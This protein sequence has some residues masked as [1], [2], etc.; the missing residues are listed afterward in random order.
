MIL[1]IPADR[2]MATYRGTGYTMAMSET[3]VAAADPQSFKKFRQ[4]SCSSP[5]AIRLIHLFKAS[6]I[7]DTERTNRNDNNREEPKKGLQK[8]LKDKPSKRDPYEPKPGGK[9]ISDSTN[10]SVDATKS[11][12]KPD[13]I[14]ALPHIKDTGKLDMDR[15]N[16]MDAGTLRRRI[17]DRVVAKQCVRCG[18]ADHRRD[19]CKEPG[20]PWEP[21]FDKGSTFWY[22]RKQQRSQLCLQGVPT[23][24]ASIL[25]AKLIVKKSLKNDLFSYPTISACIDTGSEINMCLSV[26]GINPRSC[27]PIYIAGLGGDVRFDSIVDLPILCDDDSVQLVEC[28]STT[29]AS[30]PPGKSALLGMPAIRVL[31]LSLDDCCRDPNLVRLP[32]LSPKAS[33]QVVATDAQKHRL[34]HIKSSQLTP[35]Q[36]RLH[37]TSKSSYQTHKT[38]QNHFER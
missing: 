36:H 32:K 34:H 1:H 10:K 18:S 23:S 33:H 29:C 5:L 25:S 35:K 17:W 37:H 38:K 3:A 30:L 9:K 27:H 16:K 12:H 24:F 13:T 6:N 14:E 20:L 28:F 26:Y 22:P 31:C 11:K 21:D 15:Y 8:N 4:N 7:A 19:N 2:D